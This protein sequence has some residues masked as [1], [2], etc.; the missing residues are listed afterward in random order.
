MYFQVNS[1]LV[2]RER[3][4]R[5]WWARRMWSGRRWVDCR[6]PGSMVRKWGTTTVDWE[7]AKLLREVSIDG[8]YVLGIA[9][10]PVLLPLEAMV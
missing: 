5:L 1:V 10:I 2:Y 9:V 4:Q 6:V 8:I 3:E 7:T